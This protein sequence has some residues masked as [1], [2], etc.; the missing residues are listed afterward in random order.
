MLTL[1]DE[2]NFRSFSFQSENTAHEIVKTLMTHA[3]HDFVA[4]VET[5]IVA[6][7]YEEEILPVSVNHTEYSNALICSPYTTYVTYPLGELKQFSKRWIKLAILCNAMIM[8]VIC[9][10]TRFNQIVQI[11]NN[12]NS[13]LKHPRTLNGILPQLTQK[14]IDRFPRHAITFFRVNDLLDSEF[15]ETLIQNGY[16]VFPD[17]QVHLF[18][19]DQ[20][21]MQRSHTKRDMALLRNSSYTVVTHDELT[22]EDANRIAVLYRMLFVDKHSKL[23]PVYTAEYFK[24]AILQRWH[25][26]VALRNQDGEIDGF[27]SW[28]NTENIMV[29][30]PLGYDIDVDKKSGI[31]RQLVALCLKHANESQ[32]IFNM[33][34]GS[35]AFKSNRGST[36][37]LEYTAVYCRHLTWYRRIPWKIIHYAFHKALKK[38]FA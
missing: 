5:K 13:L 2:N 28:F 11:N 30:G 25:H 10:S 36:K 7:A 1:Y 31:Y 22:V 17:R 21:V 12:L 27:I 16:Q 15:K 3:S 8:S 33:G 18:Y 29:C 35:D 20:K 38:I 37:T 32:L 14:M 6:L 26:Y 24:N 9:R 4:N 19:P 34:G 23:N